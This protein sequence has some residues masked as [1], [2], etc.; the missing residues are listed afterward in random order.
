MKKFKKMYPHVYEKYSKSLLNE[1][2]ITQGIFIAEK[3]VFSNKLTNNKEK[4]EIQEILNNEIDTILNNYAQDTYE[5]I[6]RT[7]HEIEGGKCKLYINKINLIDQ[8]D[9]LDKYSSS[10][11]SLIFVKNSQVFF[12]FM[13]DR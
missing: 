8:K 3:N 13:S 6:L 11:G 12:K 1:D 2:I 5:E 10:T 7:S 4:I 9:N